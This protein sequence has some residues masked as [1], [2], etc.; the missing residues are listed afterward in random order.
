MEVGVDVDGVEKLLWAA[1]LVGLM[2]AG[3]AFPA[4]LM[5]AMRGRF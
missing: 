2:A 1:R 3:F 5:A 4:V